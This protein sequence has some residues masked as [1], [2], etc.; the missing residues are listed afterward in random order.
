MSR[1]NGS[2]VT[3]AIIE[4]IVVSRVAV[5]VLGYQHWPAR[6]L[7]EPKN[8]AL[9]TLRWNTHLTNT[10]SCLACMISLLFLV[11]LQ[12]R[13]PQGISYLP[14]AELPQPASLTFRR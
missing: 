13:S 3:G 5:T 7:S 12:R 2:T 11:N 1:G 4:V 10:A 14:S 8:D 9:T 6:M